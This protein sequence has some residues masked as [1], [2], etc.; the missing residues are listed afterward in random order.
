MFQ[1]GVMM[2][3]MH[4]PQAHGLVKPH[5]QP[6]NELQ[7]THHCL[8]LTTNLQSIMSLVHLA[9]SWWR[10]LP[11]LGQTRLRWGLCS[12]FWLLATP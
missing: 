3:C 2:V 6:T 12:L 7:H 11:L 4:C 8:A 9:W 5:N 1:P 10:S